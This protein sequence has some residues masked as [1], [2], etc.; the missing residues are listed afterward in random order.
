V[1]ISLDIPKPFRFAN[2]ERAKEAILYVKEKYSNHPGESD[3]FHYPTTH[4]EAKKALADFFANRLPFFGDYE[5]A[6]VGKEEIL[7]HSSL[8]PLLNT[9][10]LTP[11][12]VVFGAIEHG[13]KEKISL[14]NIEGFVRQVLGWREF[15]R[16]VYHTI[17]PEQRKSNFFQHKRKIPISFYEGSTGIFPIDET[18]KKL[19][20]SAYL[21]HI[22]RLMIF[23]NFFL[24]CEI[25]PDEI[26]RWF[27]E[28]FIDSYDWVMVPNVYGMS[29]YADGG[30]MTTKPY[31]SS[32]NYILK[33][34]DFPRGKWCE[35]WD[36]LF[37]RFMIK[38]SAF[39]EKQPRLR[40]LSNLAKKKR[41]DRSLLE[42]A[43]N[44]LKGLED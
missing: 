24:L 20:K 35:I 30:M 34:S 15:V 23:G 8:S 4:F 33:M 7:F 31:F 38:H 29:Q 1:P 19:K 22:E 21:H 32:S 16:G 25:A 28:L 27:M 36:A 40:I 39:F 44:F 5:D 11:D 43:E 17:G 9:G 10:L 41:G 26:Y 3:S 37:W 14:N 13:R 2:T 18:I 12:Q 42:V 6:I